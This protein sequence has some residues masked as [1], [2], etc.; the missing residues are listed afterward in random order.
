MMRAM[1]AIGALLLLV[2][3]PRELSAQVRIG[4]QGPVRLERSHPDG[5][6][7]AISERGRF[8]CRVDRSAK[9][10]LPLAIRLVPDPIFAQPGNAVPYY[11]QSILLL[12]QRLPKDTQAFTQLELWRRMRPEKLP[13]SEVRRFLRAFAQP[14]A[15]LQ[16][17]AQ[18]DSAEWSVPPATRWES[19][20]HPEYNWL[21]RLLLLADLRVRLAI[22]EQ[23][24]SEAER[25][26][27]VGWKLARDFG[28]APVSSH[29]AM[30]RLIEGQMMDAA[31][32]WI[33][34]PDA[35]N[36]Y[37]PLANLPLPVADAKTALRRDLRAPVLA[38]TEEKPEL[39]ADRS[40]ESWKR[41][42]DRVLAVSDNRAAVPQLEDYGYEILVRGYAGAKRDLRRWG[43]T[44]EQLERLPPRA[45]MLIH[46]FHVYRHNHQAIVKWL[47]FPPELSAL[48]IE[49]TLKRLREEGWMASPASRTNREWFSPLWSTERTVM[50]YLSAIR[51]ERYIRAK[52]NA[53]MV[54]EAIR[55]HMASHGGRLPRALA[56]ITGL[57]LPDN[58]LSGRPFEYR[59]ES[60]QFAVLRI[61][62]TQ[63]DER[64]LMFGDWQ[65]LA[66][67]TR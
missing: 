12:Q 32:H 14:M 30:A 35:P 25:W 51:Q 10:E 27:Q 48:R 47:G 55:D 17:G 31:R 3:A 9:P 18:H 46:Q 57:P 62:V 65:E 6:P 28:S 16:R 1:A 13:R 64:E 58:P 22:A 45:V 42:Y 50:T 20:S 7:G 29:H 66:I 43:F 11:Y 54:V 23:D 38:I 52:R 61:A 2:V 49:E 63:E 21:L 59:W 8:R 56:E 44:P 19:D 39:K 4:P 40:D 37:W 67:E 26:L 24:Y 15:I 34:S 41:L 5:K 33:S 60:P 53:L 36:L